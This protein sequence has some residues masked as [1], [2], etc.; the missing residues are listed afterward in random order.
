V[1][2]DLLETPMRAGIVCLLLGYMLSQ[3]F[4]VFLAVLAP[5]L[6]ADIGVTIAD[7]SFASGV[8]FLV[9]ASAQ[10]PVGWALDRIGPRRT[11]AVLLGL[12]GGG[13]A[14]L[15]GLAQGPGAITLAMALIGLGCSPVLMAAYVIFARMFPPALFGTLAGAI[16]GVGSLGNLGAALPLSMAA[17]ALGWRGVMLL[18]AAAT[19]AVALAALWLVPDPRAGA[20]RPGDGGMASVLRQPGFWLVAAMMAVNYTPIAGVRGLW[21]GPYFTEVHGSSAATLGTVT[22][23]MGL[24]MAAGSFAYGPL[25]RL[26]RTRKGVVLGGN[27][28]CVAA[29]AALWLWPVPPVGVAV[30]LVTAVGLFGVSFPVIIAHGRAFFPPHLVGRGVTLLNLFGIGG[31]GLSQVLSGRVH[32]AAVA[33][34][35]APE[36]A[37]AT[38]F[39]FFALVLGAGCAIYA[40]APDRT[41]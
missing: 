26:L 2:G 14:A 1:R 9:F 31:A 30:A 37:M 11:M 16:I 27:L 28:L 24:A 38:V 19:V 22:L 6:E 33:G 39:G 40:F 35:A 13:G 36:A 17:E 3:F 21:V 41:D 4:R 8:F 20:A 34:G 7:L 23:I 29:L 15:F 18:V 12:A 5:A 10:I 32:S 25:D